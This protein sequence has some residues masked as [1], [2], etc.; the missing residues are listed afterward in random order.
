MT[1]RMPKNRAIWGDGRVWYKNNKVNSEKKEKK[2][3][4]KMCVGYVHQSRPFNFF[5]T[6]GPALVGGSLFI[7]K[8][9]QG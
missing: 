4:R 8:K 7:L 5:K 1:P 6:S 9:S 2:E 3:G